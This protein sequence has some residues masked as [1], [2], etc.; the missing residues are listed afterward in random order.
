MPEVNTARGTID[1]NDL[2]V[3][4]MHEHVFIMTTEVMQNYPESGVTT[5]R[6]RPTRSR[7]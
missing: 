3:T 1:A 4:L 5:L 6:E 2:G 7:G